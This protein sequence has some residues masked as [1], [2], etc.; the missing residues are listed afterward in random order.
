MVKRYIFCLCRGLMQSME[1]GPEVS[2]NDVRVYIYLPLSLSLHVCLCLSMKNFQVCSCY[3]RAKEA[4][5]KPCNLAT[6]SRLHHLD[7][8]LSMSLL[9]LHMKVL[10]SPFSSSLCRTLSVSPSRS[11]LQCACRTPSSCFLQSMCTCHHRTHTHSILLVITF[12][13]FNLIGVKPGSWRRKTFK[14]CAC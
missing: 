5:E 14:I 10:F 9:F 7:N 4:N 3:C 1:C 12:I 6:V 13:C 8:D 2:L 11:L